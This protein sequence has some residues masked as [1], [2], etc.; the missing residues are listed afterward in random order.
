MSTLRRYI[1]LFIFILPLPVWN[2]HT[3]LRGGVAIL[4]N[5]EESHML[6]TDDQ[7]VTG[8]SSGL[9]VI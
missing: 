1:Y 8:I 7:E 3:M 2:L 5:E 4:D 6:K 9:C